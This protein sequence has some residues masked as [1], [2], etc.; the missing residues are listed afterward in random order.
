[1]GAGK[2]SME[3]RIEVRFWSLLCALVAEKRGI[4]VAAVRSREVECFM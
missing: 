3:G 4:R 1:M 2:W